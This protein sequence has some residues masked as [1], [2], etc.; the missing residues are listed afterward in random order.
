MVEIKKDDKSDC[1]NITQTTNIEGTDFHRQMALTPDEMD[2]VFSFMRFHFVPLLGG[3][4]LKD[5]M[6]QLRLKKMGTYMPRTFYGVFNGHLISSDMTLDEA[7]EK[8]FDM[9]YKTLQDKIAAEYGHKYE[10]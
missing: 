9:D 7:Y 6:R 10:V 1:F 5:C 4:S 2:D 3:T 8:V